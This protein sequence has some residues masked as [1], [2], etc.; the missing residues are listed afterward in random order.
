MFER[1]TGVKPSKSRSEDFPTGSQRSGTL[2]DL[3]PG[4]N[5]LAK[6]GGKCHK[7]TQLMARRF[8]C[9][10]LFGNREQLNLPC[11]VRDPNKRP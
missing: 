7:F 1:R 11:H 6:S 8:G 3:F 2:R 4:Q 5:L 10:A 9:A